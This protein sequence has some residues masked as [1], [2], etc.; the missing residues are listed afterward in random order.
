M[1]DKTLEEEDVKTEASK[2][3]EFSVRASQCPWPSP[4][5]LKV[6]C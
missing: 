5:A 1:E 4:E 6:V 2:E 3:K